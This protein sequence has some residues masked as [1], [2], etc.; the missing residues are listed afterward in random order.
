[1]AAPVTTSYAQIQDSTGPQTNPTTA[2]VLADSGA[3]PSGMYQVIFVGG[4][5][6]A[7]KLDLQHRNA[8]NSGAI[9]DTITIR[10][11]AGQ[12]SQL[13]FKFAINKDERIRVLPQANITGEAEAAVQ[14]FRIG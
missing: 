13:I 7:A 10:V 11:A 3:L 2:T 5:S 14:V 8:A 1:M 12:S 4:C 9:S 6:V